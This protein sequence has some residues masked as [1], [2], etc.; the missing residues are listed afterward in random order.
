MLSAIPMSQPR[1]ALPDIPN[2]LRILMAQI[3]PHWRDNVTNNI[4]LMVRSFSEV[5]KHS[6]RD[7]VTVH[8]D[9]SYGNH[10]RNALD[11]YVLD[12]IA[13]APPVVLFVHGGAFVSGHRNRTQQIYSNVLYYLAR[14]GIAGI[15]LGYRLA[16]DAVYPEA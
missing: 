14:E 9:I 4:N 1:C 12:G 8:T 10:E 16:N 5:L 7:G 3:G 15:N 13:T 2:D 11:V 6:P